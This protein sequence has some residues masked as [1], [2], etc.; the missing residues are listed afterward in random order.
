[1]SYL[2]AERLRRRIRHAMRAALAN[3]DALLLPTAADLPPGR[4]TTGDPTL[5]TPF[6]LL[7]FPSI[8][9]PSGVAE[10]EGLPLAI[11]LATLPWHEANLLGVAAWCEA[12]LPSMPAPP[13]LA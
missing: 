7:G 10:P 2:H 1:V 3:V 8:S 4:E 11:Q 12:R 6:S 13:A 5:Q 9:L